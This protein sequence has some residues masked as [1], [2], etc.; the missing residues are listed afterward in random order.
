M[1]AFLL[2]AGLGTRLRPLTNDRPK[3]LVEVNGHTLLEINILNLIANGA[4]RIVVNVH[5][6]GDMVID[7]ISSRRWDAEILVSDER[8]CLLDTGAGLKKASQYFLPDQPVLVHNVDILSRLSLKEIYDYHIDSKSVGTLAVS[9]RPT[10][11]QL[12][13]NSDGV[14]CGWRNSSSGEEIKCENFIE[15][16]DSYAFSG[17]SV[18]SPSLWQALP[19][20][21]APYPIIPAYLKLANCHRISRFVHN[22]ADWLDVGK[23]ETLAIA[24]S[25]VTY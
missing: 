25:F 8:D 14:L 9:L 4:D 7:F 24:K 23:P 1:Q 22:P 18:V 10:S 13:F 17:I 6:F 3:A 19:P 5:H 11:R 2:A 21:D 12:L 16:V 15:P 20:A